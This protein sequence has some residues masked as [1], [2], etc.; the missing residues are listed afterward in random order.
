MENKIFDILTKVRNDELTRIDAME[1]LFTLFDIKD[2]N[3]LSCPH[4]GSCN[5][6]RY[7]GDGIYCLDCHKEI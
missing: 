1:Q 3:K 5:I 2:D 7:G 6:D 4:C